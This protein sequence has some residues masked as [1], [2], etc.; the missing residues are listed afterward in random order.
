MGTD[1]RTR[2]GVS[3]AIERRNLLNSPHC[4][5]SSTA[6]ASAA[7]T[8]AAKSV[9]L[10]GISD[11]SLADGYDA[12][13]TDVDTV[14]PKSS[15]RPAAAAAPPGARSIVARRASLPRGQECARSAIDGHAPVKRNRY[16]QLTG[17]TKS[18]NRQL[19]AKTRSLA[20]KDARVMPLRVGERRTMM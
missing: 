10:T 3:T 6:N 18:V 13:V 19:D 8:F 4:T 14:A 7:V 1:T 16:I 9:V 17:A 20:G 2:H 15:G 5:S 12:R 11:L